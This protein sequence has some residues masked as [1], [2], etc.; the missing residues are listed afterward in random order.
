MLEKVGNFSNMKLA[1]E[2]KRVG[3]KGYVFADSDLYKVMEGCAYTLA[4]HPDPALDKKMDEMIGLIA[5]AQ[6]PDG[7]IDTSFQIQE[8]DKRFTNLRDQHELYCA[9]HM[10]EAAVAHFQSTGK[11]NFLDVAL[12]CANLLYQK[13]GPD[14]KVAYCGHPE[15]ELALIKLWKATGDKRWFTLSQRM[16]EH[17]GEGYF[18]TEHNTP[19]DRYD[20][21]YWLDDMPIDAHE[22]IKGHAVRAAYLM[23][24]A[25][26]VDRETGDTNLSK[27]LNRV[28]N[29]ATQRRIFITG[30]IGPSGSNEGFTVDYDLPNMTA[31]QETCAS[32]A[33]ALWGHRMTLLFG[34]AHYMDAVESALYNG[35]LSGVALDGKTFFYVNPLASMGNHHRQPWFSCAC[36]PPNVLRT[37]ASLGGYVYATSKDSLYVNLYVGGS[38]DTQVGSQRVGMDVATDYPWSGTMAFRMKS[39]GKFAL[40]LRKPG[41]YHGADSAIKVGVNGKPF[42]VLQERG[43]LVLNQS[44]KAGDTVLLNIPMDVQQMEANPLVKDDVGKTAVQRGPLVYCVEQVDNDTP[45]NELVLPRGASFKVAFRANVL[46]G[47]AVIDSEAERATNPEWQKGLYQPAVRPTPTRVT[48]IPYGFWDN[49]KPGRM[50]VWLPS[51]PPPARIVGAEGKAEVSLSFK[52][53]N[54]QPWGI[55]DGVEPTSSGEQPNA[56]CHFWPH[57]GGEEWVQYTWRKPM[58]VKGVKIYWFDDTGRGECRLPDSWKLQA[59]VGGSWR[60]VP[61]NAAPVALNKWSDV[62]FAPVYTTALRLMVKQQ[63]GWASGIHEWKVVVA[64]D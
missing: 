32:I 49:R 60:D 7:Y 55:N 59:L 58:S 50:E 39:G 5:A 19:K 1:A 18:A 14:G 51:S 28:W 25:A 17:R 41:W 52:S 2:R 56:L 57:K 21:T 13:F 22:D 54:A 62:T 43:Y 29:S 12:K 15:V 24:G 48:L 63:E 6:M 38:M 47:V 3:F 33:M 4:T 27:M 8:P 10:F 34:D 26:D 30:G 35:M 61:L 31:Y 16:I 9:G 42:R 64:D 53:G 20:G 37:I 23:S 11:R 44:W 45:V 40:R 46:G 36:C